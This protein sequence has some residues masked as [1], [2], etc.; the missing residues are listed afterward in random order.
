MINEPEIAKKRDLV[1]AHKTIW[2]ILANRNRVEILY[3]LYESELNWSGLMFSLR[4]NPR[5]LSSHLKS[6]QEYQAVD[7]NKKKYRLTETGK[8]VCELKLKK[9]LDF[10]S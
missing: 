10:D 7:K 2:E 8:K 4:I 3:K 1:I 6:L 5:A 9:H